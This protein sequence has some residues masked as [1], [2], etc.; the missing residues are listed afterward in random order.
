MSPQDGDPEVAGTYWSTRSAVWTILALDGLMIAASGLILRRLPVGL[1]PVG[2][3]PFEP[4]VVARAFHVALLGLI[5]AGTVLRLLGTFPGTDTPPGRRARRFFWTH[6]VSA[7]AGTM[8]LPLGLA[9]GWALR[10]RLDGV[11]PFWAVA[12]VLGFLALPRTDEW[13]ASDTSIS[14]SRHRTSPTEAEA[15]Q[16]QDPSRS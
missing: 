15:P 5:V 12:I 13:A 10:P 14:R 1:A 6:V 7:L 4:S 9:Y 2:F 8:A 3:L 11:G 16:P